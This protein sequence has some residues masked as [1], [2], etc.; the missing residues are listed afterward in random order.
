MHSDRQAEGS[1]ILEI[2]QPIDY[3]EPEPIYRWMFEAGPQ[4][5]PAP[6][7]TMTVSGEA[8]NAAA[9]RPDPLSSEGIYYLGNLRPLIPFRHPPDGRRPASDEPRMTR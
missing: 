3:R 7:V 1:S 9:E 8:V 5:K 2:Q 4:A 6:G